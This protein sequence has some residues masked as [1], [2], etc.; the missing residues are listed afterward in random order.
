MTHAFA[1]KHQVSHPKLSSFYAMNYDDNNNNNAPQDFF[2]SKTM[3]AALIFGGFSFTLDADG[4][5]KSD[6]IETF[7]TLSGEICSLLSNPIIESDILRDISHVALDFFSLFAPEEVLLRAVVIL[8]RIAS[9]SADY[10]PDH[11]IKPSEILSQAIM[12]II[13]IFLFIGAVF[14][15][16]SAVLAFRIRY[17]LQLYFDTISGTSRKHI[18]HEKV[19][20]RDLFAWEYLF[21]PSGL[22]PS[23]FYRLSA[24]GVIDWIS[25]DSSKEIVNENDESDYLYWLYRGNAELLFNGKRIDYLETSVG[26]NSSLN[27]TEYIGLFGDMN[28]LCGLDRE[29][30]QSNTKNGETPV[31]CRFG[32][33]ASILSGSKGSRLMRINK[34]KLVEVFDGDIAMKR[35]VRSLLEKGMQS[36]L[37]AF[38]INE[39]QIANAGPPLFVEMREDPI[40]FQNQME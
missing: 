22:T 1:P 37:E 24:S 4:I 32:K 9:M 5:M 16:S 3:S 27:T 40:S 21:K 35:V 17:Q 31:S 11:Y 12:L 29:V 38:L 39:S 25:V 6:P 30:H 36:M 14:P 15:L 8:G 2:Q 18:V 26:K 28:F 19:T 33:Q 23:Q 13:S 34:K 7:N 10:L 20:R